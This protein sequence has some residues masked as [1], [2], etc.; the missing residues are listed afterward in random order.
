LIGKA[1]LTID[2]YS[3]LAS[4][5]FLFGNE[6]NSTWRELFTI[7]KQKKN[8]EQTQVTL[9]QL[10]DSIELDY[11]DYLNKII[12]DYLNNPAT[13]KDWR[14]YFVKYPEM[15]KGNSGVYWWCNDS[16]RVKQNQYEVIMMNTA[17]SLN[18]KHWDP[19]LY[20][21]YT[22]LAFKGEFSLEEYAA[23]LIINKTNQR[24]R[25]KNNSWDIFD[26]NNELIKSIDIPQDN[27]VD[28]IDRIEFFKEQFNSIV[29]I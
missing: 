2:D 1:L 14:Y 28:T 23:P 3:Q 5:R 19:F 24:V 10:L 6:N 20:V 4:W 13:L 26:N 17:L 16:Q 8:F 18:G 29:E 21:L 7:S 11:L 9:L 12:T 22:D 25:C 27:G 15:R